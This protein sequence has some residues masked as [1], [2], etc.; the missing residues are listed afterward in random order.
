[1]TPFPIQRRLL[2]WSHSNVGSFA[3]VFDTVIET[4][5]T[6][7]EDMTATVY[8]CKFSESVRLHPELFKHSR[9]S[10]PLLNVSEALDHS[11]KASKLVNYSNRDNFL[12]ICIRGN[13]DGWTRSTAFSSDPGW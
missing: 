10:M 2:N 8:D 12:W 9:I 3:S 7:L 4:N 5:D 1:M 13:R 6:I 11:K